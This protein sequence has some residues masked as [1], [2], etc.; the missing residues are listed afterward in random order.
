MRPWGTRNPNA[1]RAPLLLP[2][3]ALASVAEP[4]RAEGRIDM[5]T[6]VEALE[7]RLD[8]LTRRVS[9]LETAIREAGGVAAAAPGTKDRPA[10]VFDTYVQGSPFRVLQ[11]ELDRASGRVDLLLDVVAELPDKE[12]WPAAAQGGQ[13]PLVLVAEPAYRAPGAPVPLVLERATR[14]VTGARLHLSARLDSTEA[15]SLRR[16]RIGHVDAQIQETR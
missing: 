8:A 15:Q 1:L 14:I 13:V 4:I 11:Q 6:R 9:G 5:D 2:L 10:W 12:R 7:A 3:I 16:I